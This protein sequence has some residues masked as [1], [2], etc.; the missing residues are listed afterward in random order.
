MKRSISRLRGTAGTGRA[1]GRPG[2]HAPEAALPATV[3]T[4]CA[5]ARARRKERRRGGRTT[6]PELIELC[7]EAGAGATIDLRIGGKLGPT[8]GDPLDLRVTVRAIVDDHRQTAM[9]SSAPAPLGRSVWVSVDGIDIVLASVRSQVFFPDAFTGLGIPLETCRIIALKSTHHFW[10]GFSSIAKRAMY[11]NAPGALQLDFANIA[12]RTRASRTTGRGLRTSHDG[13]P[14]SL[15]RT[16]R[17]R[18]AGGRPRLR[19]HRQRR[20]ALRARV[21]R[22]A[23]RWRER[24]DRRPHALRHR[25]PGLEVVH[26]NGAWR[27]S[28]TRA[29][30]RGI[31]A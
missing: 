1:C 22:S 19:R 16:S 6:I 3:R 15:H 14:R 18:L 30:F 29:S 26:W 10:A 7:A 8:S 17:R 28:S 20:D 4:C 11:V 24:G 5:V 23:A 27:C 21:R 31:V 25:L 9:D 13:Y 2:Q 12:Y